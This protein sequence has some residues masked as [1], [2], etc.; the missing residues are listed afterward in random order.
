MGWSIMRE[1]WNLWDLSPTTPAPTQ[2]SLNTQASVMIPTLL[3][4]L[5]F[6][7][8]RPTAKGKVQVL[9]AASIAA[10]LSATYASGPVT[11][12]HRW[13]KLRPEAN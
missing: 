13:D 2:E 11:S 4:G 5:P 7:A 9:I 3:D 8:N 1:D 6:G 10:A 12:P